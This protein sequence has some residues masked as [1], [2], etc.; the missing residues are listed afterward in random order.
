MKSHPAEQSD[1]TKHRPRR[2]QQSQK[3]W[4]VG[5]Y[6]IA[7]AYIESA[8][9]V[10][11]RRLYGI[12]DLVRDVLAMDPTIA[13]IEIGREAAT[14][15]MLLAVGWIA[16]RSRRARLGFAF[17]TFGVWDIFY[18]VW[19]RVFIG[20][21]GSILDPDILFL[22]PLPWWGPVLAPVLIAALMVAG[23]ALTVIHDDRGQRVAF[24]LVEWASLG[25]GSLTALY[26]F[27]ADALAALPA[28]AETLNQLRP[29]AF[30]WPV[31]L[32]G[33]AL[34]AWPV[35]MALWRSERSGGQQ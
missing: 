21:P 19:L 4:W 26:A 31:Y 5:L 29:T 11:L 6:A 33:L 22:I 32:A 24:R 12:N 2:E 30:M 3:L 23:G 28:D 10:Y 13:A 34:M 17:F 7:M 18:Y 1:I 27:M 35:V 20:W 25:L 8:V 16:G 14:L 15:L 9:V